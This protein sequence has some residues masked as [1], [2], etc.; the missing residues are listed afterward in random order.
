MKLSSDS[1]IS[2]QKLTHYLLVSNEE[3]DKSKFLAKGGYT[4]DSWEV[5]AADLRALLNEE[6]T[7]QRQNE[8]GDFF[9]ITGQLGGGITVKTIWLLEHGQD[10]ARFI[11]LIPIT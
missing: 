5:L 4:L 1:V 9:E 10:V 7:L 11:T 3:G 8:F 2:S 6:A